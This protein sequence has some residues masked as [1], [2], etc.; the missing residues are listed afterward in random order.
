M[1]RGNALRPSV[2]G[3]EASDAT[4]GAP[5]S[6][7]SPFYRRV[8]GAFTPPGG[9]EQKL[10]V[11]GGRPPMG[12][13]RA[14][15][16]P[17][18]PTRAALLAPSTPPTHCPGRA[19]RLEAVRAPLATL[20]PVALHTRDE[21]RRSVPLRKLPW[22]IEPQ[23]RS[24]RAVTGLSAE[25]L[26]RVRAAVT[27]AGE[28]ASPEEVARIAG[29]TLRTILADVEPHKDDASARGEEPVCEYGDDF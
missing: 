10:L 18:P 9:R 24:G 7:G 13:P 25:A 26:A 12:L 15:G 8:R 14:T 20:L 2:S 11:W 3:K 19:T 29:A 4:F 23:P 27:A 6:A 5:A 1:L 22:S 21:A 28:G 17:P 16:D